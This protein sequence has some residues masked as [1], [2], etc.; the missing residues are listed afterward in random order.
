V[1]IERHLTV[2]EIKESLSIS[3]SEAYRLANRLRHIRIGRSLR[4]PISAFEEW[5]DEAEIVPPTVDEILIR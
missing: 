3:Q 5:Y 2:K 4:V 1:S